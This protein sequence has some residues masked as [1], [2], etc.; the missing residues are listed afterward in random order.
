MREL[1][2]NTAIWEELEPPVNK[3]KWEK[4]V[5]GKKGQ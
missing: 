1:D 3:V 5:K 2:S 4:T